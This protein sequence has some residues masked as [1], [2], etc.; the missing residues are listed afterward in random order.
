MQQL[1]GE[2]LSNSEL[3]RDV[4]NSFARASPFVDETQRT[5]SDDDDVYHFIAYTPINNTLYE[6][7][8]LQPAP[9]SHG[10]CTFSDFPEKVIPVLQ[11]RI[12]RYPANEIRF[13]LLAM[14]R[15]L[16]IRARE[17]GDQDMLYRETQ[18][19]N[20]WQWENAL[21]RHNFVGFVSEVLKGVVREKLKE[22]DGAYEKWVEEAVGRTKA[23]IEERGKKGGGGGEEEL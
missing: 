2:A 4:H 5:A 3:I 22:G 21:R 20:A 23:R 16:R 9:I 19:R 13:N 12:N 8:G 18:K 6:L 15:D 11:R 7:D 17:I 14:V 10:P 1:R